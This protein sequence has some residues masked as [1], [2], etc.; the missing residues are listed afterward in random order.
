MAKRKIRQRFQIYVSI[1][2][3]PENNAR[4]S[5]QIF[6][7]TGIFVPTVRQRS[8]T[9][10]SQ[11]NL[12]GRDNVPLE[13]RSGSMFLALGETH[14]TRNKQKRTSTNNLF[15]SLPARG[16]GGK[17]TEAIRRNSAP[18]SGASDR[19]RASTS[20]TSAIQLVTAIDK[21]SW[22]LLS[23]TTIDYDFLI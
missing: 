20:G 16:T 13:P 6:C 3:I 12:N 7:Q 1:I 23:G 14:G 8:L 21:L 4:G 18:P 2:P 11:N 15:L 22:I 5:G 19:Q 9:R 10:S 17:G